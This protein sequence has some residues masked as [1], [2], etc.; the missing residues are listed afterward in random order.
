VRQVIRV[1]K[2]PVTLIILLAILGYG[3]VW[4]YQQVT[5]PDNRKVATCVMTD[6]GA[7]L[8]P[9][10]VTVRVLNGGEIGGLA[11]LMA[12]YL[13]SHGFRVIYYNN[14]DQRVPNTVVVG[15]SVDDPEVK[16][17]LGF[18]TGSTA[19][20]DGRADHGVDVIL[21]DKDTHI[22]NPV[23]SIP[24]TGPVCLPAIATSTVS[25]IPTPSPS[26]RATKKK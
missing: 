11:K 25:A 15:N 14:S 22:E 3:A 17:M 13:R 24:V 4:G 10:R 26:P 7:N 9:D 18:F 23:A 2:T 1:I 12:G 8:T 20:G 6:V 16:L 19:K 5:M 21:G